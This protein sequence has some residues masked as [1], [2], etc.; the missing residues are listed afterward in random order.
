MGATGISIWAGMD[1]TIYIN[2][3]FIWEGI[4][5]GF[6]KKNFIYCCFTIYIKFIF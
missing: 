1:G 6:S 5:N 2:S 3:D 4:S